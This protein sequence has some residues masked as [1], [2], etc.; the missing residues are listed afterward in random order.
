MAGGVRNVPKPGEESAVKQALT[1][2]DMAAQEVILHA[3]LDLYP[4]VA[5]AAEEDTPSV[6]RFPSSSGALVVIDPIDGTL[7]SYLE[8][9]GPYA[10]IVGLAID[11]QLVS[12]IV[13][14]PREGQTFLG[15]IACG[16]VR[17]APDGTT[18]SVVASA[19]GDLVLVSHE[20]PRRV[21]G[22][23]RAEGLRPVPACGGAIAIAPLIRGV[24]AG[25]R[26]APG[27]LP[28]GISIRGRVGTL[29]AR[30]AGAHLH[31]D[32]GLDFPTDLDTPTRALI[33]AADPADLPL[34]EKCLLQAG[35]A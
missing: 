13:A 29:I 35:R 30:E 24:R 26:Y 4:N 18:R 19:D 23:L 15:E 11:R 17:I 10:V 33:V 3:L 34:L 14:L 20:M 27:S 1:A 25:L 16:A 31:G 12:S 5:L 22:A 32:G 28:H 2:A 21:V 9:R 8:E 7:H 6:A